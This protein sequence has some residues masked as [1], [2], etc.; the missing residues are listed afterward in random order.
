MA[1]ILQPELAADAI[2]FAA[3]HP[4]REVHVGA[5]VLRAI[6]GHAVAPG[7]LDR[8]LARVGIDGQRSHRPPHAGPSNLFEPVPGDQGAHGDF[9]LHARGWDPL[10]TVGAWLGAAGLRTIAAVAGVLLIAGVARIGLR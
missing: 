1:P 8:Y 7:V 10:A 2:H 3:H 6:A 9:E 4:R 5:P